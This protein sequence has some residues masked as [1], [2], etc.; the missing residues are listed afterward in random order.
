MYR[1]DSL[2]QGAATMYSVENCIGAK[3]AVF[4]SGAELGEKIFYKGDDWYD[5]GLKSGWG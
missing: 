4:Y 1:Y 5:L 3:Q 2:K